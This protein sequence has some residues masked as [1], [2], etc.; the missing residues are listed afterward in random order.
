MMLCDVITFPHL[1]LIEGLLYARHCAR[2]LGIK[3]NKT[4]PLPAVREANMIYFL[5]QEILSAKKNIK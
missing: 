1:L 4:E 3:V 5:Y 2:L